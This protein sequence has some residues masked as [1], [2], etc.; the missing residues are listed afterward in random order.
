MGVETMTKSLIHED[1]VQIAGRMAYPLIDGEAIPGVSWYR[2]DP[3]KVTICT[4]AGWANEETREYDIERLTL[5]GFLEDHST[6][7][8]PKSDNP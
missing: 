3:H 5:S 4:N 2:I 8:F 1:E 7:D 6:M